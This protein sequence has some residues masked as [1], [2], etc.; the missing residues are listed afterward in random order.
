[1][2]FGI[3]PE[4]K[5]RR[6]G[7]RQGQQDERRRQKAAF[8]EDQFHI[9]M[10]KRKVG[11]NPRKV[12]DEQPIHKTKDLPYPN[13]PKRSKGNKGNQPKPP[14]PNFIK[15][16]N[17]NPNS[18]EG[19]ESPTPARNTRQFKKQGKACEI[20]PTL[21]TG[22]SAVHHKAKNQVVINHGLKIERDS[23]IWMTNANHY[24]KVSSVNNTYKT[25]KHEA[26]HNG[27]ISESSLY[28]MLNAI[29]NEAFWMAKE[30]HEWD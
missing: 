1:M 7:Y 5:A 22:G 29:A 18:D 20:K 24:S 21:P 17:E 9:D 13:R 16:G 14:P 11:I 3:S 26:D 15:H 23:H 4:E 2:F 6:K 27:R 30:G 12:D 28:G 19:E 8:D 25:L 10:E